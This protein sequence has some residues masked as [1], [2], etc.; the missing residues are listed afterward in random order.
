MPIRLRLPLVSTVERVNDGD[1]LP[2]VAER[3][4]D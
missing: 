3:L 2:A 4:P 1:T